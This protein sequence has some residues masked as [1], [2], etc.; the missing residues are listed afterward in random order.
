[1]SKL[2]DYALSP[3]KRVI[4]TVSLLLAALI[5]VADYATGHMLSLAP[6]YLIAICWACWAAGRRAGLVLAAVSAVIWLVADMATGY[7]YPNRT[8]LYW[9][10]LMLLVL[11][12]G[13]VLLLAAFRAAHDHLE[14]TVQLR[15]AAL[16]QEMADRTRA[17][18]AKLQAERLATVGTMAAKMAHEVRNPLGSITLN[19]DLVGKEI[20]ELAGDSKHSAEEGRLLVEEIRSEIHRIKRVI[21]DYL[22]FARPREPKRQP[23]AVNALLEHRLAFLFDT[24]EQ[25]RVKLRTE[26]DPTLVDVHADAD[27]IWEAVLNLVQNSLEAMPDGGEL[28]VSTRREDK[29]AL[30]RVTDTGT[31]INPEQLALVFRP[32]FTTKTAGTGLGLAVVQQIAVENGGYIDCDSVEGRGSTFTIFLP[33]AERS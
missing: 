3:P 7:S 9:N 5:G 16:Q 26:F 15:T 13:V 19:L 10:A 4:V 29:Q 21:D 1:M 28:F 23:L 20:A 31:G 25:A 30:L 32:F 24:F 11:F 27:Q 12:I 17:E 8:I 2:M 33:L 18:Q 14:E 6:L 22:Q